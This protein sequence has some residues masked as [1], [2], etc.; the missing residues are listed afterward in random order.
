MKNAIIFA[1]L[2]AA[3]STGGH[4]A[5]FTCKELTQASVGMAMLRAQGHS[6]QVVMR[7]FGGADKLLDVVIKDIYA[8]RLTPNQASAHVSR[9]CGRKK[10]C[11]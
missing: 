2:L 5:G 7:E 9:L 4:A 3:T 8:L 1:A 6:Y 10:S 11:G